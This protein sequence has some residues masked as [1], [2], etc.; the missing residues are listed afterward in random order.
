[1][2][3][4]ATDIPLLSIKA[5]NAALAGELKDAVCRV[6]DSGAFILGPENKAFDA[7]FADAVGAPFC[8]GVDSGTSALELALEA[9]GVGPGDEV[10]VPS[11]T[12]IATAT[13][14][15]V[16]GATPVF[17]DVDEA[18]LTLDPRSVAALVGPKTKAIVPVHLFGHPADMEPLLALARSKGLKVVEDCAQSHLATYKGKGTGTLGDAG[19]FS[20][21]PTKN[22]GA[23]GDAGAITISDSGLRDRILELRNCGRTIGATYHHARVGH[24]CRLDE[25]QAAVLR[26]KLRHLKAWT[27]ARRR[28]AGLYAEGLRGLPLRLPPA[29]GSGTD[30]VFHL[31][32]VRL[33]GRDALAGHLKSKGIGC[34]VYYPIPVHLQPAYAHLKARVPLTVSE[35]ASREALSLPMF[36]ELGDADVARVIAAVRGFLR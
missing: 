12:F 22:L 32:T 35:R 20:F 3:A 18:T 28:V 24:N 36:A 19:G 30:P 21:Y 17:A 29:G 8:L 26:V 4:T 5:Q 15:S 23:A 27:A 9:V 16:L 25:V 13:A 34:G 6:L 1:M 10:I 2:T 11:F 33:E 7:E 14:V 31:Y